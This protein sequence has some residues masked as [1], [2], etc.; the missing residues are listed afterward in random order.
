MYRLGQDGGIYMEGFTIFT[1]LVLAM[2]YKIIMMT[3]TLTYIN[4][5]LWWISILGY[6][7]FTWVYGL[8]PGIDYNAWYHTV[9]FSF[10]TIQYWLAIIC[11][12]ILFVIVDYCFDYTLSAIYPTSVD[13]LRSKLAEKPRT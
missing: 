1:V 10:Q 8:I 3:N 11:I 6:L 2:Q 12:P 13:Q 5:G 7:L 4:W 9:N